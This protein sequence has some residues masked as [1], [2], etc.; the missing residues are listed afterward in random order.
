MLY[1]SNVFPCAA[2]K[3]SAGSLGRLWDRT[4]FSI[5]PLHLWRTL[6]RHCCHQ[7]KTM[8]SPPQ[9]RHLVDLSPPDS[10][11]QGAGVPNPWMHPQTSSSDTR[12]IIETVESDDGVYDNE[13]R[14][15]KT[16]VNS[17]QRWVEGLTPTVEASHPGLYIVVE[18]GRQAPQVLTTWH[19]ANIARGVEGIVRG[20]VTM[21]RTA[22]ERV[23]SRPPNDSPVKLGFLVL[24]CTSC[25]KTT[26]L[27]RHS[28]WV[29]NLNPSLRSVLVSPHRLPATR[30]HLIVLTGPSAILV[31]LLKC[32]VPRPN[33]SDGFDGRSTPSSTAPPPPRSSSEIKDSHAMPRHGTAADFLM[34]PPS[35]LSSA[36]GLFPVLIIPAA[37]C[38]VP[39]CSVLQAGIAL[40]ISAV[41]EVDSN[42]A[43]YRRS[44]I[45]PTNH[46]YFLC[47]YESQ[48]R[49]VGFM[50]ANISRDNDSLLSAVS[51]WT[52]GRTDD[53]ALLLGHHG[54]LLAGILSQ[55]SGTS[56]YSRNAFEVGKRY[57]VGEFHND[58]LPPSWNFALFAA[59]MTATEPSR[60][61]HHDNTAK[62]IEHGR[63]KDI[64]PV[65]IYAQ[66][67]RRTSTIA[68]N[69]DNSRTGYAPLKSHAD[70][71]PSFPPDEHP[72]TPLVGWD[73]LYA[74]QKTIPYSLRG[75]NL[76][77]SHLPRNLL[78]LDYLPCCA[79]TE[80]H[81][82]LPRA[83]YSPSD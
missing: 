36:C 63:L 41:A 10:S 35:V 69:D 2:H 55:A 25:D 32:V 75:S 11:G 7:T 81:P 78:T 52:A 61:T 74:I 45:R 39:L 65:F 70:T 46:S 57:H 18:Q 12:V 24:S 34:G 56:K 51:S 15:L 64:S 43:V 68:T 77:Q 1:K 13:N 53:N 21:R 8:L 82:P 71:R 40:D 76:P 66:Q 3:G 67:L 80:H 27:S 14:V 60:M 54:Q 5:Q 62:G 16:V 23:Q 20:L 42:V 19:G 9:E 79:S 44:N 72:S 48:R 31:G 50:G 49:R 83:I 30:A 29:V 47:L 59:P 28:V 6:L 17:S 37:F 4:Q 22:V 33:E 26:V 38:S 73:A 58:S